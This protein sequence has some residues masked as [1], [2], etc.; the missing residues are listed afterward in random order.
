MVDMSVGEQNVVDSFKRYQRGAV[1]ECAEFFL[2]LEQ[3]AVHK[4]PQAL[5]F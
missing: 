5:R 3:A 1:V 4:Q 2:S